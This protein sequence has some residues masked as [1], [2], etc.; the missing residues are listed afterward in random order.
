[1]ESCLSLEY[2][3]LILRIIYLAGMSSEK[4][5]SKREQALHDA[6][7]GQ[8][9]E[10]PRPEPM[11]GKKELDED[12]NATNNENIIEGRRKAARKMSRNI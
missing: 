2:I 3:L 11:P 10:E 1:L 8:F 5:P 12:R 9:G 4:N 7:H 6:T